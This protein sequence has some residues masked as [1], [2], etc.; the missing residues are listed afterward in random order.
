MDN[1]KNQRLVNYLSAILLIGVIAVVSYTIYTQRLGSRSTTSTTTT[2]IPKIKVRLDN[3]PS[4]LEKEKKYFI[5][6]EELMFLLEKIGIENLSDIMTDPDVQ[7]DLLGFFE[8]WFIQTLNQQPINN[9][10]PI[11][12]LSMAMRMMNDDLLL[13]VSNFSQP[14]GFRQNDFVFFGVNVNDVLKSQKIPFTQDDVF[15]FCGITQPSLSLPG[16]DL[17]YSNFG[18]IW[19]FE[20]GEI[21]CS[22]GLKMNI[23]H[24]GFSTGFLQ[25]NLYQMKIYL[26]NQETAS[27]IN[28]ASSFSEAEEI[29]NNYQLIYNREVNISFEQ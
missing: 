5:S 25:D 29:L 9:S 13:I 6:N 17:Y 10:N 4:I 28:E 14:E 8:P 26:A 1:N 21:S 18:K 12:E 3:I 15:Y 22:K 27:K 20:E 24:L 19:N 23:E 11:R 16:V 2:T 7:A